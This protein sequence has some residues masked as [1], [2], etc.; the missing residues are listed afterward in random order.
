MCSAPRP[1]CRSLLCGSVSFLSLEPR[2]EKSARFLASPEHYSSRHNGF[3]IVFLTKKLTSGSTLPT[4]VAQAVQA[5]G[6]PG[7]FASSGCRRG[8]VRRWGPCARAFRSRRIAGAV[9]GS[10]LSSGASRKGRHWPGGHLPSHFRSCA[11]PSEPRFWAVLSR[12]PCTALASLSHTKYFLWPRRWGVALPSGAG[13]GAHSQTLRSDPPAARGA[14]SSAHRKQ[15]DHM[16]SPPGRGRVAAHSCA[17]SQRKKC[18]D[19]VTTQG[20]QCQDLGPSRNGDSSAM[21]RVQQCV[22]PR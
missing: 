17:A 16:S 20:K 7:C 10:Q 15:P 13:A 5:S 14:V 21:R 2:S 18:P 3:K 1:C 11:C 9:T 12:P 6:P 4:W 22:Q 8:G 19:Q